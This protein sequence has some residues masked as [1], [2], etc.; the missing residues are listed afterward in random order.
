LKIN[1]DLIFGVNLYEVGLC[2]RVEQ[3]FAELVAG[4]GI[5]RATF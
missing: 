3:L 1:P 2:K 4:T 5:I